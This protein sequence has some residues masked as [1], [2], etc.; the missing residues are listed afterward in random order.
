MRRTSETFTHEIAYVKPDGSYAAESFQSASPDQ[1]GAMQ[2]FLNS[3]MAVEAVALPPADA[4][5]AEKQTW[6]KD[7]EAFVQEW[8]ASGSQVFI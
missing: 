8:E 1:A 3:R 2:E 4:T 5:F 6:I 7:H